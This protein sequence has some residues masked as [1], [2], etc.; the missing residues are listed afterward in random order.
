MLAEV[1]G[2]Q[3]A[4]PVYRLL[5]H[6]GTLVAIADQS[7]N[8]T[9]THLMTPYGETSPPIPAVRIPL[10]ASI[11]TRSKASSMPSSPISY[12]T[13]TFTGLLFHCNP[14]RFC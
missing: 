6:E 2:T 13:S 8:V 12:C 3:A 4:T 1:A 9:A 14:G 11:M 10:W 7:G 5:D